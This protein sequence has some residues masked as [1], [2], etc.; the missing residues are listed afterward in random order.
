MEQGQG[1]TYNTGRA[2][3]AFFPALVGF[4]ADSRGVL[5]FGAVGYGLA[6]LAVSRRSDSP[7]RATVN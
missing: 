3:G 7:G 6:V 1:F 4:L 2:V 5:V